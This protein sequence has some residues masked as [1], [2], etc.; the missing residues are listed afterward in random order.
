MK[1]VTSIKVYG[2]AKTPTPEVVATPTFS[3]AEGTYTT[4]Q[5]VAISC[6][7]TDATIH[8]TTDGSTPTATS[9]TYTGPIAV[10][11]T[12]TIKAIAVKDGMTNSE[13]AS[14]TYTINIPAT[15]DFDFTGTTNKWN[16]Q[17]GIEEASFK[18][19]PVLQDISGCSRYPYGSK[20]G[21]RQ[22][23]G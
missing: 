23:Y 16:I 5:N 13:V 22:G 20:E 12:T 2:Y 17:S 14:A 21:R 8:Y 7:T 3:P 9:D 15:I 6:A 19:Y 11:T 4:A 10:N 1:G 18:E